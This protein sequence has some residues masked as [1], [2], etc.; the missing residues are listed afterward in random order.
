[1]LQPHSAVQRSDRIISPEIA[2]D[3]PEDRGLVTPQHAC[4]LSDRH[5]RVPPV[6]NSTTFLHAQLRI[7]GA[8][9]MFSLLDNSLFSNK[10]INSR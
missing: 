3:L 9:A 7:Y 4:H 1:M 2:F 5:L 8:R 6:F 10:G